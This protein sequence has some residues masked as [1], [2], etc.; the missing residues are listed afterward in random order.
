MAKPETTESGKA[1]GGREARGG[2]RDG[3]P[4]DLAARADRSLKGVDRLLRRSP[5]M[6]AHE[7]AMA[8][9]EQAKVLALLQLAKAIRERQK[10]EPPH[11]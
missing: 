11:A 1:S 9:L 10:A 4:R 6:P 8:Q 2:K 3:G 7:K 5:T